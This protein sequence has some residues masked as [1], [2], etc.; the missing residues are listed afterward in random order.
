DCVL[1][2]L[3]VYYIILCVSFYWLG[4][5]RDLHSFPTRRSSDLGALVALLW[6]AFHDG[7]QILDANA[8]GARLV[9]ARLVRN[10]H[11][12]PQGD[13]VGVL[14]NSLRSLVHRKIAADAVAGAVIKVQSD[15]PEGMAR[16]YVELTAARAMGKACP[17][18]RDMPLENPGVAVTH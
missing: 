10:D 16:Q 3:T 5:P 17:R 13:G 2:S 18:E 12:R 4:A 15:L 1:P 6:R 8:V 11:S 14:R 7:H 9:V